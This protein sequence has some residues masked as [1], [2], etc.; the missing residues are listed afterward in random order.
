M[1][2][3]AVLGSGSTGADSTADLEADPEGDVGASV[4][5]DPNC[6][7]RNGLRDKIH[8]GRFICGSRGRSRCLYPDGGPG[9][10]P[11]HI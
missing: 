11:R 9:V 2:P 4:G 6:G 1:D 10:D 8:V 7:S 3:G 5:A